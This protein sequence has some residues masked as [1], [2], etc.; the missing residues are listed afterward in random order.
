MLRKGVGV[1]P[2]VVLLEWFSFC[3]AGWLK[4]QALLAV[5]SESFSFSFLE[6]LERIV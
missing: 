4:L 3:L 6:G 1:W 5:P 2:G